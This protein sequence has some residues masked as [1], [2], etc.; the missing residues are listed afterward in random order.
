MEFL[1]VGFLVVKRLTPDVSYCSPQ[2]YAIH[3]PQSTTLFHSIHSI[4][5]L[6]DF[7]LMTLFMGLERVIM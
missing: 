7:R 4:G 2:E 5:L 3:K 6:W 1:W